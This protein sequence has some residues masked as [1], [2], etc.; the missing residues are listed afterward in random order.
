MRSRI[1]V[2]FFYR[3]TFYAPKKTEFFWCHNHLRCVTHMTE[4][5]LHVH[6]HVVGVSEMHD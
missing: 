5:R 3:T 6:R 1:N 2:V 4:E